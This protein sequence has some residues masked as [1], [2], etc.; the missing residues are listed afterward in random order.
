MSSIAEAASVSRDTSVP[1]A[2]SAS[3]QAALSAY[4]RA[5]S[6]GS[7]PRSASPSSAIADSD[8]KTATTGSSSA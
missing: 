8:P 3:P 5:R 7:P 1:S 2:T 6:A 4:A